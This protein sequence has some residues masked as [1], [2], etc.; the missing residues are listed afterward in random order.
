ML[1][2]Y[3]RSGQGLILNNSETGE[4]IELDFLYH[5]PPYSHYRINGSD[6]KKKDKDCFYLDSIEEI[7]IVII[8]VDKAVRFGI[9]APRKWNIARK[10]QLQQESPT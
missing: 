5:D 7:M 4:R 9:D 6:I 10:E 1:V 8:S 3:R 2:L